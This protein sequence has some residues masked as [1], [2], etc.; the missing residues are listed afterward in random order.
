MH[1]IQQIGD[2]SCQI[3]D[4]ESDRQMD[5]VNITSMNFNSIR[6]SIINKLETSVR[7]K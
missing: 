5:V 3:S 6:S 7:Q 2:E 4:E 1:D